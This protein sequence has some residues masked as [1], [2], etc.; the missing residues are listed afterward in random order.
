MFLTKKFLLCV[1]CKSAKEILQKD[2]QNIVS[3]HIFARWQ[4]IRSVFYFEIEFIKGDSN[5]LIDFLS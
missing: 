5:F 4:V 1:D 3:K 2:V